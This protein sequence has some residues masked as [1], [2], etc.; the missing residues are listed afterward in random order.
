[1]DLDA[2]LAQVKDD[3]KKWVKM[4][5]GVESTAIRES[6]DEIDE[7]EDDDESM[8][9]DS[10]S[11]MNSDEDFEVPEAL[12]S[13]DEDSAPAA[14]TGESMEVEGD[15]NDSD[16]D[17]EEEVIETKQNLLRVAPIKRK[18]KGDQPDKPVIPMTEFETLINPQLN[19]QRKKAL[20][21]TKKREEKGKRV[22]TATDLRWNANAMDVEGGDEGMDETPQ[23]YNFAEFY[24]EGMFSFSLVFV[25]FISLLY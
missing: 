15:E 10:E 7:E 1:M 17:S 21:K 6:E 2:E 19:Q 3:S 22:L 11:E 16:D 8:D 4:V 24:G 13:E 14:W 9:E 18:K 5:T 23:R 25:F 20:K 12:M